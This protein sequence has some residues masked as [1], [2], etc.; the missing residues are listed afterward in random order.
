MPLKVGEARS[1]WQ[2]RITLL[3]ANIQNTL[4]NLPISSETGPARILLDSYDRPPYKRYQDSDTPLNRILIR[5]G[6]GEPRDMAETSPVIAGAETFSVSR[7]YVFR[8]D[9]EARDV[10]ESTMK[11][12]MQGCNNGEA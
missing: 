8:D 7:V 4:K 1:T 3:C 9:A 5:T 12:E 10:V 11:T 6:I 2:A